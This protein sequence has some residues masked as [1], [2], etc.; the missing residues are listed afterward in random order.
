MKRILFT[1]LAV[2][3]CVF[4]IAQPCTIDSSYVNSSSD[5]LLY[6]APDTTFGQDPTLG[7]TKS[8]CANNFFE[9]TLTVVLPDSILAAGFSIP[10]T[11]LRLLTV[12][13]RTINGNP[14]TTGLENFVCDVS[15][16]T[17]LGGE[18]GCIKLSGQVTAPVGQYYLFL[19]T[20]IVS[21]AIPI[22]IA[23][24]I[25]NPSLS[26][27]EYLLNVGSFTGI[28]DVVNSCGP[29]TWID[30][31]TY[32]SNNNTA[33]F[34]LPGGS[35]SVCDTVV[36]LDLTIHGTTPGTDVINACGP[37]T[38]I[39]GNTYSSNNTTATYLLPNASQYGC[40]SLVTL[41]LTIHGTATGVDIVTACFAHTWIDG[42]TYT[43]S[44][45]TATFLIAG[46]S[47]YGCDSLV[48]LDL[49]IITTVTGTDVVNACISHTW[50]DGNTYT[51][52]N[53]T[54]T[55]LIPNGSSAGCDS[56]VTLDLTLVSVSTS[57][58]IS[59]NDL[60]AV[61]TGASYQWL[62]C[63]NGYSAIPGETN[64]TF[65]T[66][67]SGSYAVEIS[68][69]NCIDTSSCF[70]IVWT[71][72][73]EQVL[74]KQ[75]LVHPNPTTGKINI[76]FQSLVNQPTVGIVNIWGQTIYKEIH[77]STE[78]LAI[79]FTGDSGIYMLFV[80]LEDGTT[81]WFKLIKHE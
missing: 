14:I 43:S 49:T 25:P 19:G 29:Y 6:P 50:I 39:D 12:E 33:T 24:E 64:Q 41:D 13:F 2:F 81:K 21:P 37:Y 40:D 55:H 58:T 34:L 65:M 72:T 11:S 28:D 68:K 27:G 38:W 30:G 15:N 67:N 16:C 1:T 22:P 3:A 45:N 31:N 26:S 76:E 57:V 73:E 62:D 42:N 78:R 70:S 47:Q 77:N 44:N 32:S 66:M 75:I 4:V 23:L 36:T 7:I 35:A 8:A 10:L 63:S 61:E 51:S 5:F 17:W 52:N 79:D 18:L 53:N 48:T 74:E 71:N 46:G 59:Y 54:A 80:E 56:L 20:E 9:Y 69:F 60:T